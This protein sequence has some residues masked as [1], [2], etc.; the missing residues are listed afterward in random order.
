M[1]VH[2]W[3]VRVDVAANDD[4]EKWV[5]SACLLC[6]N[7]KTSKVVGVRSRAT[8]RVNKG[9]LGPR[10]LYGW[11]AIHS[12]DR[13]TH[14]LIRRNGKLEKA[15]WDEAMELVVQKSKELL[16]RITAHSIAFYTMGQL[17]LEEY[18][19]LALIG[20]AGLQTFYV[21]AS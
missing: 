12:K 1:Y 10:G 18:Y 6:S 13:L 21:Y 16:R 9:R 3:L 5:H 14:P 8:D 19:A 11:K 2:E 17:F 20:K 15:S 4:P 7:E